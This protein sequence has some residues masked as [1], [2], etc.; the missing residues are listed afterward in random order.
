MMLKNHM[1]ILVERALVE[2]LPRFPD[3]CGCERCRLDM[4]AHALNNLP[5][6]YVVAERG[7]T[8]FNLE[9]TSAQFASDVLYAVS[10]AIRL[11]GMRPRHAK[12]N[13]GNR[14]LEDPAE[15]G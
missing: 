8:H 2:A 7:L 6:R 10:D 12:F 9:A 14:L 5:A 4:M 15:D 3:T 11:I 13:V 1:E